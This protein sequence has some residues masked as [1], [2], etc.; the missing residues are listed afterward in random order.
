LDGEDGVERLVADP[1]IRKKCDV[2]RSF[3]EEI[4]SDGPMDLIPYVMP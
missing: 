2:I 1:E 3:A 4:E